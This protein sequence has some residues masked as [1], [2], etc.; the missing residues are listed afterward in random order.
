[1]NA[2]TVTLTSCVLLAAVTI[3]YGI[4]LARNVLTGPL[5]RRDDL[6]ALIDA[7]REHNGLTPRYT[8]AQ[9]ETLARDAA[10][11]AGCPLCQTEDEAP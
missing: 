5:I 7:T 3:P 4:R 10:R 8:P 6:E 1:V 2:V 9:L 11:R